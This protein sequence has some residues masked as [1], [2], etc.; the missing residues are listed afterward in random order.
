MGKTFCIIEGNIE[1]IQPMEQDRIAWFEQRMRRIEYIEIT[2]YFADLAGK[3][4]CFG[5]SQSYIEPFTAVKAAAFHQ[6]EEGRYVVVALQHNQFLYLNPFLHDR[7]INY[8]QSFNI[9]FWHLGLTIIWAFQHLLD[10]DST[11]QGTL[12]GS[13]VVIGTL[14]IISG[15]IKLKKKFDER[16]A[17]RLELMQVFNLPDHLQNLIFDR[18]WRYEG[19]MG[20]VNL[21]KLNEDIMQPKI[22]RSL[23]SLKGE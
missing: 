10:K 2:H 17:W 5:I 20:V 11:L 22:L 1:K 14:C 15:Y 3:S 18:R 16:K 19:A 4:I 7:A 8:A 13:L 6:P 21:V 9:E 12:V 23:F